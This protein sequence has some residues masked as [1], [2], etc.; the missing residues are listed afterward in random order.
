MFM[1][2]STKET[3]K[4]NT[5]KEGNELT[6]AFALWINTSKA[7]NKYLSGTLS[8][9]LGHGKLVGYYN[10][11][12]KNPKEPDIRIYNLDSEGHQDHEVADLWDSVSETSGT[13]YLTGISDEKERLIGFYNDGNV[14]TNRPY[15]RVYFKN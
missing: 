13:E 1:K 10:T 11:N 6:E 9:K 14:S 8:D 15:I 12:K 2:T 5:V 4:N 3:K 7:G